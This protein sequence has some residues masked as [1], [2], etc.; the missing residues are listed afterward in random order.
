[1][2]RLSRRTAFV[3]LFALAAVAAPLSAQ[4]PAPQQASR[5]TVSFD[6]ATIQDVIAFFA[7]Y[8]GR[9]IVAGS[10]VAGTVT[11]TIADQPWDVA[12]GALLASNGLAARELQ[13]GII[14]VENAGATVEVPGRLVSRIFRLNYQRAGELEPVVR[15]MLSARGSVAT[16]ASI[17]ALVVTDEERVLAQIASVLGQI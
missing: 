17:N 11:A 14:M 6:R 4:Q 9:S 15:T 3:A 7:R 13:S 1:M 5:V 12:L 8:S 16:V 2:S 10:G